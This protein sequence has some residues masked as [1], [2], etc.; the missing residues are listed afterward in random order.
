MSS[1]YNAGTRRLTNEELKQ[2]NS[3]HVIDK[4]QKELNILRKNYN[5]LKAAHDRLLR[6][7][8]V[9]FRKL[10]EERDR[11]RKKYKSDIQTLERNI[12][13]LSGQA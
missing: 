2:S 7:V 6:D 10:K 11:E 5:D 9:E 4:L 3:K 12:K 1:I 8:N 13:R